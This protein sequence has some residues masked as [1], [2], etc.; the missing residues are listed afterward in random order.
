VLLAGRVLAGDGAAVAQRILGQAAFISTIVNGNADGSGLIAP[1]A[2]AIDPGGHL[3]VADVG[4]NRI[5]GWRNAQD[6]TDGAPADLVLGQPDFSSGQCNQG[7]LAP[8]A[9]TLCLG[10]GESFAGFLKPALAI[11]RSGNLYVADNLNNRVLVYAAPFASCAAF[12][13]VGGPAIV[14]FG[15]DGSF[16]NGNCNA[17]SAPGDIG[18]LGPDS[19]CEP[20]GI[21]LD[22]QDNL[23]ISDGGNSRVLE[24]NTPLARN[25]PNTT[26]DAV[27]GQGDSF[28]S[29]LCSNGGPNPMPSAGGLCLTGEIAVDSQDN[30]YVA[31][32]GNNRV[33]EFNRPLATNPPNTTANLVFGQN[34]NFTANACGD[35]LAGDPPLSAAGLCQPIA[36]SVDSS[37]DLY[38]GDSG[39]NRVLKYTQP[40]S[41]TPSGVADGVFPAGAMTMPTPCGDGRRSPLPVGADTLCN[42]QGLAVDSADNLWI[43]DAGANRV[44]AVSPA[45]SLAS[46]ALGQADLAHDGP[47]NLDGAGMQPVAAALDAQGHLYVADTANSRVL[48]YFSAGAVLDGGSA[49]LVIG[50]PDFRSGDCNQ[51]GEAPT[52]ATLCQPQGL[53]T[54]RNGNLYVAD[55]G[56]NRVLEFNSPFSG[57]A[58]APCIGAAAEA[59]Y[60][61]AD[62][63]TLAR[64]GDGDSSIGDPA[65]SSATLCAPHGVAIDSSGNLYIADSGANRV[66]VYSASA[67]QPPAITASVVFGQAG[68][69]SAH[70][71]AGVDTP[72]IDAAGLC[73]PEGLAVDAA[74]NVYIADSN[75]HRLL[76]YRQP[77]GSVLPSNTI[78]NLVVGQNG[79]F[80]TNRCA[81]GS[82]GLCLPTTLALDSSGDL[83]VTD[84]DNSRVLEFLAPIGS[85][86]SAAVVY[87]QN[88]NFSTSG[89]NDGQMASDRNGIGPDSLCFPSGLALDTKG[90]PYIADQANNRLLIF[91]PGTAPTPTPTLGP[92]ESP[93][94]TFSATAPAPTPS[95]T[96]R[97]S[98]APSSFPT[99]S[100]GLS[101]T[102]RLIGAGN[103]SGSAG[104]TVSGGVVSLINSGNE[105]ETLTAVNVS[106]SNPALFTSLALSAQAG[107][108][109]AVTSRAQ[110][111]T[112]VIFSYRPALQ[113]EPNG[114]LTLTLLAT[115]SAQA[116]SAPLAGTGALP[117]VN[118]ETK[119]ASLVDSFLLPQNGELPLLVAGLL[120]GSLSLAVGQRKRWRAAS[121]A[122]LLL[123][124]AASAVACGGSGSGGS[125]GVI[126]SPASATSAQVLEAIS[127]GAGNRQAAV[128]GLPLSLGVITRQ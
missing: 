31:D 52:A 118:H 96:P 65:T 87:G 115:L 34:D 127:A 84:T 45:L 123:A 33:L 69:F 58:A 14:V 62:S 22:S 50:Q 20:S 119:T 120:L 92:S 90:N 128:N 91:A 109:S 7:A 10:D 46:M 81:A 23:Y 126:G 73:Q 56:N 102:V 105:P 107:T 8:G 17:G 108:T 89:C 3:Y 100:A 111:Q 39:N 57:C 66:L 72:A 97:P 2:L 64:C 38:I 82:A 30:L 4:N 93:T 76:I 85:N 35:G 12:P 125:P 51:G 83:F 104:A 43:A 36:L 1:S 11:D 21:A 5:L 47:N 28:L 9:G 79:S 74:N 32:S 37:G 99:P 53:V 49:D 117:S 86:S 101:A 27:F 106:L 63:F 67:G 121:I 80:T 103:S 116:A 13:C 24:F 59:V 112:T 41:I 42:P 124:L 94:P 16:A 18:G 110:A 122:W 113:I 61:Q 44:L 48:G 77:A 26:A 78:A 114:G 60:G 88:G 29:A 25:P 98:A 6:R 70:S 95:P 68:D 40:L 71:C 54:D 55:G 15:Q 75:N 19:L